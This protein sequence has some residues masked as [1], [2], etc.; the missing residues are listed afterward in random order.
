MS[1]S[2]RTRLALLEELFDAARGLAAEARE[3]FLRERCAGDAELAAELRQLLE[4]DTRG[5]SLLDS[6]PD[7]WVGATF[8]RWRAVRRLGA[9]GMGVVYL[10]ERDDGAFRQQAALKLLRHG[11]ERPE[12]VER[13]REERQILAALSHASIA[14]LIDGGTTADGLPWLVMEY[15]AGERI[16]RWCD[17]RRLGPRARLELF[18]RVCDGVHYAHQRL[19]VHRDL[20]PGNVL[21]TEEGRPVLVD[22]GISRVVE[23]VG[24]QA[25][26]RDGYLT[27]AYAAPEIQRGE[28]A[29][30]ASDVY[31]LGVL[32]RELLGG[33]PRGDLEAIGARALAPDPDARYASVQ[34][35][36]DDVGRALA[37]RPVRAREPSAG[38]ALARFVRRNRIACA[39]GALAVIGLLGGTLASLRAAHVAREHARATQRVNELLGGML[40]ELDPIAS[41]GLSNALVGQLAAAVRRLDEGLLADQ[42][43]AEL[44][45]RTTLGRAYL[46]LGYGAPAATQFERTLELAQRGEG[47]GS[48]RAVRL[49]VLR[50]AALRTAARFQ[51]AAECLEPAVASL[52]EL[53]T[54]ER[55]VRD[56]LVTALHELGL[57]LPSLG[58]PAEARA[59]LSEGLELRRALDGE[60]NESAAALQ[61]ALAMALLLDGDAAG[62]EPLAR[63]A[64]AVRERL[65]PPEDPRRAFSDHTL[66]RI[67]IDLGRPAEALPHA[68]RALAARRTLYD[69]ASPPLGWSWTLHGRVL[70]LLGRPAEAAR[71]FDEALAVARASAPDDT[72]QLEALLLAAGLA[73]VDAGEAQTGRAQLAEALALGVGDAQSENHD[74]ERARALLAPH[75]K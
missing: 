7:P 67:L 74:R 5:D 11:L 53:D 3:A 68:E 29:R 57:A 28:G 66:A 44:E 56:A 17:Q 59:A 20:K 75:S 63:A 34:D 41:R 49:L 72:R 30:T 8:E 61:N 58:R 50:G 2:A 35:L 27:P 62:A 48:L 25:S 54:G 31:S 23:A 39:A 45:M 52:R 16:D 69:P 73:R 12:L 9:G 37:H 51:A 36:S 18:R 21:V 71:S 38:Y 24:A 14:R 19:V 70:A 32:L 47:A 55:A 64:A 26:V 42:P 33:F 60:E 65:H 22:F 40:V 4:L 1:D 15:V 6:P 10:A 46:G 13:F 43:A